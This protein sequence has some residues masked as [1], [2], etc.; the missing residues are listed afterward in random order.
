MDVKPIL[1]SIRS[2]PDFNNAGMILVHHGVVRETSKDGRPVS[3]L[4]LSVDRKRLAEIVAVEKSRPGIIDVRVEI[5][6]ARELVPGD[7][8]MIIAVAG[9]VRENVIPALERILNAVKKEV[10]KKEE[11]LIQGRSSQHM[12]EEGRR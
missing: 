6:A 4:T 9:D 2:R 12:L 1:D 3:G 5:T 11:H 8:I 7:D 10:T